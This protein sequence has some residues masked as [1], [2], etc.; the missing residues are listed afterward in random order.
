MKATIYLS[1]ALLSPLA[2][3]EQSRGKKDSLEVES[4]HHTFS[5]TISKANNIKELTGFWFTPHA[6][7]INIKLLAD[8]SFIFNDYNQALEREEQLTGKYEVNG[9][10]LTLIY[11]D[12]ARQNFRFYKGKG[13]DNNYYIKKPGYYFVKGEEP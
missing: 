11:M 7:T 12:R 2:S 13:A 4:T 10:T 8:K 9:N 6:A 1:I 5:K 3:C